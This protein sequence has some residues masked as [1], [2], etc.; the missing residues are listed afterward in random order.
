M[1]SQ[2][3]IVE[4]NVRKSKDLIM[5][6]K[7]KIIK[8]ANQCCQKMVQRGGGVKNLYVRVLEE[9]IISIKA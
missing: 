9:G 2:I 5:E 6:N 3:H 7:E 8:Y 1:I 4:T